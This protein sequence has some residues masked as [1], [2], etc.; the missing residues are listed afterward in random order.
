MFLGAP[1]KGLETEDT[2]TRT[3]PRGLFRN[4]SL[5]RGP[6]QSTLCDPSC[7]RVR[8]TDL[9]SLLTLWTRMSFRLSRPGPEVDGEEE[10]GRQGGGTRGRS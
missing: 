6:A 10:T 4:F 5:T 7:L 8:Y 9:G 3:F 1:R 2:G